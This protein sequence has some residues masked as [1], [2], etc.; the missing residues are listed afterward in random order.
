VT[1]AVT[2]WDEILHRPLSGVRRVVATEPSGSIA[3]FAVAGPTRPK[4]LPEPITRPV[5][6]RALYVLRSRYG[7]GLGQ[8]L[9][10][11]VL[12]RE[13]AAELWVFQDNGRAQAFYRR[14][15]FTTDGAE[16]VDERFP[17][18]LEIRMVR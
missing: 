5:E 17:E 1:N 10:D 14:N 9:L 8:S 2:T 11:A 16:Y 3:G 7:T 13:T 4:D 18:L 12:D 15:G 6:L